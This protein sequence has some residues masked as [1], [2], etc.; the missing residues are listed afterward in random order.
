MRIGM[1]MMLSL[2]RGGMLGEC[3]CLG[4]LGKLGR[5]GADDGV[6]YAVDCMILE[7]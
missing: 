5:L 6:W 2:M 4:D 3:A 7:G 1:V